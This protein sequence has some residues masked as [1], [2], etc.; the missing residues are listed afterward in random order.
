[1][2]FDDRYI[3]YRSEN[4]E[5]LS[6]RKYLENIRPYSWD[7]I[8]NLKTK[9]SGKWEKHLIIKMN[10]VSMAGSV[11]YLQLHSK[12][13]NSAIMTGFDTDEINE[14]MFESIVQRYQV[15]LET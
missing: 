2:H 12:S 4:D 9:R 8:D 7:M 6:V 15:G 13:N 11:E 3:K 1:M 10:F 14:E 5:Q